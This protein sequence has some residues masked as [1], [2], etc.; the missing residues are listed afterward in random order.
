[1]S[2]TP[3]CLQNV[4]GL[5]QTPCDCYIDKPAD[6]NTSDSG[7]YLDELLPI[8]EFTDL[9]NCE[10]TTI[11]D[12]ME[13][14]RE[15]AIK[16]YIADMKAEL[17]K[18]NELAYKYFT[19]KIGEGKGKTVQNYSGAFAGIILRCRPVPE[20]KIKLTAIGG[21]FNTTGT[22]HIYVMDNLGNLIAEYDINTTANVY[23]NN[24]LSTSLELPLYSEQTEVL[25]YYLFYADTAIK[26]L[27]NTLTCSSCTGFVHCWDLGERC[28]GMA[29]KNKR[30]DWTKYLQVSGFTFNDLADLYDINYGMSSALYGLTVDIEAWCDMDKMF[31]VDKYEASA[32]G[33]AQ[34]QAIRYKAA[35]IAIRN[36]LLS[37]KLTR[38]QMINKETL[39][40]YQTIWRAEYDV[41]KAT[42]VKNL[43][44]NMTS[45]LKCRDVWNMKSQLAVS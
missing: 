22:K 10:D 39:L 31:C 16:V 28:W 32:I 5:S 18:E 12:V 20:G 24:T 29:Q 37:D 21:I 40:S 30:F 26:P 1:M 43:D 34:A 25:H 35:E 13:L 6:F 11:W 38:S 15:Q 3:D 41:L 9:E 45:C 19:G 8:N 44:H 7:Y 23:V 27:N 17:L 2:V 33:N 36:K 14:A 42:I 4:I